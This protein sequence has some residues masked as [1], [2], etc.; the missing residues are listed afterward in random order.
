[1]HGSRMEILGDKVVSKRFEEN[2]LYE[3]NTKLGYEYE[4]AIRSKDFIA[5]VFLIII[6]QIGSNFILFNFKI[7][8]EKQFG[9]EV[10]SV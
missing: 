9:D 3:K 4:K 8:G 1:M 10:P 6:N 7:I 2:L 5:L